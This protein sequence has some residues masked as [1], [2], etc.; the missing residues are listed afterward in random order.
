MNFIEQQDDL[1][2][3]LQNVKK[4]L[5]SCCLINLKN[6]NNIDAMK[7]FNSFYGK[8]HFESVTVNDD[9][10]WILPYMTASHITVNGFEIPF[11]FIEKCVSASVYICD[12]NMLS[13]PPDCK[14]KYKIK[15]L[16]VDVN[17][18]VELQNFK[19]LQTLNI[20][21]KSKVVGI[22]HLS[23]LKTVKAAIESVNCCE[24]DDLEKQN[25]NFSFVE[26]HE[27]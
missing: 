10:L 12:D 15:S 5:M 27:Y 11:N 21:R 2:L 3:F 14:W 19:N 25:T 26:K 4:L 13:Q 1:I 7:R 23:K 24:I 20:D 22:N 16:H 6:L 9:V 17:G 8:P 18:A